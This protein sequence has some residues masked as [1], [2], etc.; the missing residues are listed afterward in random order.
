MLRLKEPAVLLR[1]RK[2]DVVLVEGVL[3]S[4]KEEYAQKANVHQPEIVIDDVYLPP[5]PTY[6]NAHG[7]FW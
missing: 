5:V 1:C 6:H 7:P 4:A 2:D 3:D